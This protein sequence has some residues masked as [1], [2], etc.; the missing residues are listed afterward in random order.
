MGRASSPLLCRGGSRAEA[1]YC[2]SILELA[3]DFE[4][5]RVA[6]GPGDPEAPPHRKDHPGIL[7]AMRGHVYTIT[8][9]P[10]KRNEPKSLVQTVKAK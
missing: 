8:V 5:Y 10:D 3:D 4:N 9:V 2:D 6:H 1:E 7:A